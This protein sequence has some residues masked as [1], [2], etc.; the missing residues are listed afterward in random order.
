METRER[1]CIECKVDI[2]NQHHNVVRCETHQANH[3]KKRYHKKSAG[4]CQDC[5]GPIESERHGNSLLCDN[6][7]GKHKKVYSE[8]RREFKPKVEPMPKEYVDLLSHK[9]EDELEREQSSKKKQEDRE[10]LRRLT[11]G[12][13]NITISQTKP[14]NVRLKTKRTKR[15]KKIKRIIKVRRRQRGL[16]M[17]DLATLWE[18]RRILSRHEKEAG[19]IPEEEN[20]DT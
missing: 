14:S 18:W 13:R 8:S 6:C 11:E 16:N 10:R 12:S 20:D 5:S 9:K 7:L 15:P 2:S 1:V 3:R 17:G 19:V 4:I